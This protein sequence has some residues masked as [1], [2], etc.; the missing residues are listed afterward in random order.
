M[1]KLELK[2]KNQILSSMIAKLLAETGVSDINPGSIILTLL[3]LAA[4]ED[5]NQYYQMLNI[6]RNYNLDTTTGSDLD[7]RAFEYGL[8]R[9]SAVAATGKIRVQRP[10]SFEK[11]STLVYT[12][13]PAPVSGDTTLRVNDASNVLF[14]TSG[15]L[16]IGR[17]TANEEEITYSTAPVDNTNYWEF[18]VSPFSNDH[19]LDDTVILKQGTD[20][21]IPAGTNVRVLGTSNSPEI[22]FTITQDVTLLS[23]E[24]EVDNVDISS[25]TIGSIGNIPT[26]SITG[27][28]AFASPP[29]TGA[30]ATNDS[31]FTTGRD[32]ET[33]EELRDR[34]KSHIQSLSKGTATALQTAIVGATDEESAKRVVSANII[35]PTL[36][37]DPVKI[38][39]DDG[40]GFEPSFSQQGFETIL[41]Q[42][43]GGEERLQLDIFPVVKAQVESFSA[44]PFDMSSGSLTLIYTV[45]LE[46]ETITFIPQDFEF[47]NAVTA[48]EVI[49]VI[50]DNTTLLEARTSEVGKKIVLSAISDENEDIQ[51]T[52]GTSNSIFL[53][54][55]DKKS[56][57]FLYIDDIL[58]SKDGNTAFID[59]I[60]ESF[61]FTTLGA[62]PWPLTMIIDGRSSNPIT[63]NFL[64]SDFVNATSAT[65]E[66]VIAVINEQ[67]P[68]VIASLINNSTIVRIQSNT[69]NSSSSKVQITGGTANTVLQFSTSEVSGTDKDYTFN[70]WLGQIELTNPLDSNQLVTSGSQYTRAKVRAG[71]SEFY[72]ISSGQVIVLTIDGGSS[73]TITFTSTGIYS[74][75]QAA[76]LINNQLIGGIAYSRESGST[77][78]LEISTNSYEESIGSIQIDTGLT[79]ASSLNLPGGLKENQ[80]PH[81]AYRTSSIA[82]PWDFVQNDNL[83]VVLDNSPATKTFNV[84][85]D[86]DG[87]ITSGSSTT[88]FTNSSFNT[89]FTEDDILNDFYIF[90]KTGNNTTTGAVIDINDEGGNIFRYS[91]DNLPANLANFAIGDNV[92]FIGFANEEN[93]G[94]FLITNVNT[95]GNGYIEVTNANG[96]DNSSASGNATLGQ[97]RQIMAYNGTSG[98]ITVGSAF[99][100]T[101]SASEEF[102]ILPSTLANLVNYMKNTKITTLP[103]FAYIE[104]AENDSKLQIS[105]KLNG[106]DGYVQVTGGTANLKLGFSTTQFQGLQGYNYYIGLIKLVHR[107]LYGDDQNTVSFPGILAAGVTAQ[108]LAPTVKEVEINVNLTLSE[109]SSLSNVDQEVRSAI[110]GYINNLG[111]GED[112]IVAEFCDR[113]IGITNVNDVQVILPA[114]NIT[115]D[116]NEI[117]RTRTSLI[118]IG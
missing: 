115:I 64:T 19:N 108:I 114:S 2:T 83:I 7:D 6:I 39:I 82:G 105:S 51:I 93:N 53:F 62:D 35:E 106:S 79:T 47:P 110:T 78:Y 25:N 109:G 113:I 24:A 32:L 31:K 23:G 56:T 33:D 1:A 74:A 86:Y 17:G 61:D 89:V 13:L 66:E 15:T 20:Q 11:V 69:K 9:L 97:R 102:S 85:M 8:T 14:S 71:S 49:A 46:S 10:A 55:T 28:D 87:T 43:T 5:F 94:N 45:G 111:V 22:S 34:I 42:S 50:N 68:G 118:T 100:N 104:E 59:S 76:A 107:I 30:R 98:Q 92:E 77:N 41:T 52:G 88:V 96:I 63:V 67:A 112:V 72:S 117:A 90:F 54:P 48:E 65:A 40:T 16:I 37:T 80:R 116:D 70:P 26:E 91:F 36:L 95:A 75:E 21:L 12:G 4:T 101:P 99:T 29:F 81:R 103:R 57:L 27:E 18:T 3:E 44:E 60:T 73:Q 38:Y 58:L 84:I